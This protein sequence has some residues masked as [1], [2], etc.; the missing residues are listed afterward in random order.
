MTNTPETEVETKWRRA[1]RRRRSSRFLKGPIQLELLQQA[2]RLP[3]KALAVYVAIRHRSD[4]QSSSEV[5]LPGDYLAAWGIDRDAKR[6]A[7][8]VLED[9]GLILVIERRPGRSTIVALTKSNSEIGEQERQ[10]ETRK[11]R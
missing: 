6:R 8:A 5:T 4:L 7:L 2:A 9:S 11:S 3:G 1:Q 10:T